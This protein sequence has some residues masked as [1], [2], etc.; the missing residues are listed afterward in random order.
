M[1]WNYEWPE[2]EH[3]PNCSGVISSRRLRSCGRCGAALHRENE[4]SVA[5][6]RS[7]ENE[8]AEIEAARLSRRREATRKRRDRRRA[9]L[10]YGV[11]LGIFGG[12]GHDW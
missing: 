7:V 6:T 3:C 10:N 1:K 4:L 12:V 9:R 8:I 2:A 5:A 11:A